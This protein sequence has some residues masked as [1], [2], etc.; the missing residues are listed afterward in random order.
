[1]TA[2]N[3]KTP[4][5]TPSGATKSGATSPAATGPGAKSTGKAPAGSHGAARPVTARAGDTP[6][7]GRIT[8]PG[9][10]SIS[11]RAL[12][13]GAL[14]VGETVVDGLL[15]GE[16]VLATAAAMRALGAQIE[17][18]G[19]RWHVHGV[20]VGGLLEP[21]AVLDMGNAG[22]AARL[23]AGLLATH[24]LTAFLTG[25]AS[26]RRRPM[27]R[28]REPLERFGA[29][30]VL[31]RGDRLPCAIIGAE[32]PVPI[33]YTLPVASAQVKSAVLLAGLNT[34]GDTVVIEPKPTRDHTETML[35]AF[36]A[37]LRME[38]V[39]GG[40][41]I[42]L[43]GQPELHPLA[44]A[45]PGDPSSAAFPAVAVALCRGAQLAIENVGLNPLRTG[46]YDCLRE[47][48]VA[49]E[50]TNRRTE[51]GEPVGTINVHGSRLR[52]IQV[53]PAR[54]PSMI[55]E[56]PALA[57]AAACA[58]GETRI[59]GAL[60]L[61]VKESDRISAMAAGLRAAGVEVRELPDGMVIQ[62]N[63]RP[64]RGGATIVTQLDHRIAM[65]FLVLGTV[66]AE[67]VTVDDGAMIET[68]FPGFIALMQRLGA[69][70]E[71][72]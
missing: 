7:A 66:T 57:I 9:D 21:E 13:L 23:I 20:G 8:V 1:M 27:G 64:P 61:R 14:A 39:A 71:M 48:G 38:N 33:S 31:R 51:G 11:H 60:E 15:E 67:P 55:D 42:T 47:M 36:G 24:P 19:G 28:V 35:T 18:R 43:T 70:I 5:A 54:V 32:A 2:P 65:A 63:G 56:I 68:S 59:T 49:I 37:A 46:F 26:L 10:K 25:D 52:G 17:R 30:F 4:A 40:R 29:R 69:R 16:D 22:T 50:V 6:L 34:P 45:V 58:E 62:G 3:A 53:P 44:I 41:R 12:I 72:A